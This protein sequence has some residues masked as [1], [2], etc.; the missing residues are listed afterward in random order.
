MNIEILY[1]D[2]CPNWRLVE[3]SVT[4][5]AA[6]LGIDAKVS[7]TTVDTPE[8]AERLSFRGSPTLLIEGNDPWANPDAPVGLS[9]RVYRTEA[10][11]AGSPSAGQIEEALHAAL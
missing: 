6:S 2:D 9:C 5:L 4:S 1:F 10:G 3:E 7:L 11:F 8:D